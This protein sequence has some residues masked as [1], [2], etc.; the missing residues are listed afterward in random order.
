MTGAA[1]GGA[2]NPTLP[3]FR[4][5]D[6]DDDLAEDM[7]DPE[8][9]HR[10][11]DLAWSLPS[12][13]EPSPG[14]PPSPSRE[15][16]ERLAR[17]R[18]L[19]RRALRR[20]EQ[21]AAA[22]GPLLVDSVAAAV[23]AGR[24]RARRRRPGAAAPPTAAAAAASG[25]RAR[26]ARPAAAATAAP[27]PRPPRLAPLHV[28]RSPTPGFSIGGSV[29]AAAAAAAALLA[30]AQAP[31]RG[32]GSGRDRERRRPPPA[33]AGAPGAG[34]PPRPC[35]LRGR[36]AVRGGDGLLALAAAAGL[37]VAPGVGGPGAGGAVEADGGRRSGRRFGG[38]EGA[39]A[40]ALLDAQHL[41]GPATSVDE[42]SGYD[43]DDDGEEDRGR[44][45]SQEALLGN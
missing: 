11:P 5:E 27:R 25:R 3:R 7:S 17:E 31:G 15:I 24:R 1:G 44:M 34:P 37:S 21:A 18:A 45:G 35:L 23:A 41:F 33:P 20:R 26:S 42:G 28:D 38:R 43:G 19:E 30:Q 2:G 16:R 6:D 39:E 4:A 12:S 13:R 40:Q 22:G 29:A 14:R 8:T 36:E 10:R 9:I 32:S